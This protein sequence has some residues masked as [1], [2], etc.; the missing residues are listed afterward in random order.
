[1]AQK[2]SIFEEVGETQRPAAT[3]GGVTRDRGRARARV[4]GWLMVLF[5]LVV[6]MVAVGGL[7]RL[8]DSGLSITEWAPLS[9]AIPPLSAED[10]AREF[11]A[12]RQIPEYQLQNRGMSLDEFKVIYWWEWGHRQLG[13]VIGLVW[14]IGFF[15]L[16]ATRNIPPGWTG[17]LFLLG[18]LGGAQGAIGWW[19]VHSGLQE[20]MLDV[21]SYRL[22]THLGLA[23]LILGLIAWY[24]FKLGREE[25]QLMQA[26]RDGDRKLKGMATGL[27]H[28][29]FL[30]IVIG[31][32][33]AGI[34]AGRNYI[35]WPLMAG[36]FLPPNFWVLEPGWRNLFEN[37]GTVQFIHRM[38]G[39]LVFLLAIGAWVASR[40][41]AR[42]ATKRAFDWVAVMVFG[43]VVLGIVTV[44]HSSPW[45]IAIWHQLGAVAVLVLVLRARFLSMYPLPQSVKGAK[46]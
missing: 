17:R 34:D 31:A 25:A 26:R 3:P 39:Y 16:L 27:L 37:D 45:Y 11:D 9:G 15:G 10:W 41:T 12:Y 33:V 4:R 43:Q 18:V 23:F 13:R 30:Q 28:L 6:T 36:G 44:M 29:S 20:G 46:A 21:A 22:A 8:T 35:D 24:I 32:L 1:M 19:M 5:A 7:T 38:V 40:R 14:A 2:R 42:V